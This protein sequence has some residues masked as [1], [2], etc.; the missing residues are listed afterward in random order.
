[1]LKLSKREKEVLELCLTSADQ[2]VV[3]AHLRINPDQISVHK[4]R[5]NRKIANAQKFLR[6]MR[7]YKLVLHPPRKYKGI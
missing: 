3:A 2:K 7:R 5:V 6:Q 4:T 1:M